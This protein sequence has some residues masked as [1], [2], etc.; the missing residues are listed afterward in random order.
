MVKAHPDQVGL[1]SM[2]FD[3][4]SKSF[5]GLSNIKPCRWTQDSQVPS[6]P[7]ELMDHELDQET[8]SKCLEVEPQGL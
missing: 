3:K 2:A 6:A 4:P 7:R 5:L 1:P 8:G